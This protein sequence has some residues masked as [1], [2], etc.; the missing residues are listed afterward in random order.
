[1]PHRPCVATGAD[2]NASL[3]GGGGALLLSRRGLL[4]VAGK[5]ED[6]ERDHEAAGGRPHRGDSTPEVA[7][8]LGASHLREKARGEQ[9]VT[10]CVDGTAKQETP[11]ALGISRGGWHFW[12][13]PP[14]SR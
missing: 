1:M 8:T 6:H 13:Q 12:Y 5:R 3:D 14:R 7:G 9:T 10:R 11:Q 4:R 2:D